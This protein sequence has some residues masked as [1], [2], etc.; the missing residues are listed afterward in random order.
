MEPILQDLFFL[1]S[2]HYSLLLSLSLYRSPLLSLSVCQLLTV[3]PFQ[4]NNSR[5]A[6]CGKEKEKKVLSNQVMSM[7]SCRGWHVGN[8]LMSIWAAAGGWD[9]C[10]RYDFWH[11]GFDFTREEESW[12]IY[13]DASTIKPDV[14]LFLSQNTTDISISIETSFH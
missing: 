12:T 7:H 10:H 2:F 6:L 11:T 13:N 14:L 3:P 4:G 1:F 5:L 9:V 8:R